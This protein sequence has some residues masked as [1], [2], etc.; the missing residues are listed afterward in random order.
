MKRILL[1]TFLAVSPAFAES[2]FVT[3]LPFSPDKEAFLE[4]MSKEDYEQVGKVNFFVAN[5]CGQ[6][7]NLDGLTPG[8]PMRLNQNAYRCMDAYYKINIP[9]GTE[10]CRVTNL[11]YQGVRRWKGEIYPAKSGFRKDRCRFKD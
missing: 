2:E 6:P 10:V 7:R 1:A 3:S 4:W 9:L 8:A 11:Y 5:D